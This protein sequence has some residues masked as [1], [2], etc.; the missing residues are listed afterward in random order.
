MGANRVGDRSRGQRDERRLNVGGGNVEAGEPRVEPFGVEQVAPGA[1]RR[2]PLEVRLREQ[3]REQ[4]GVDAPRAS[5]RAVAVECVA[6]VPRV[7]EVEQHV[8][9]TGVEAAHLAAL[10]QIGQVGDAADVHDHAMRAAAEER[11]VERRHQRRT[12]AAGGDVAAPEIGDDRDAR[13]LGDARRI[14]ELQRPALVGTVAQRLAVDA[15][16]DDVVRREAGTVER[17]VDRVGARVGQ[18]IG[19]TRGARELVVTGALQ[20][21]QLGGEGRRE[22]NVRCGQ[23]RAGRPA[24]GAKS[25][26]TASTPSRL[27][28]DI[29]PA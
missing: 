6:A 24:A 27:V 19:G 21:D 3:R 22:R 7:P 4:R 26:T 20:R 13:L 29:T 17:G 9:G 23:Q 12:L 5:P 28:P 14:V 10:R 8:A 18:R 25:A 11:R 2:W 1:L 15:C 16:R